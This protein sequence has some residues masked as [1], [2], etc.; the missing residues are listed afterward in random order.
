VIITGIERRRRWSATEKLRIV[1]ETPGP[2]AMTKAVAERHGFST[3]LLFTWPKQMLTTAMTG[4]APV[5]ASPE[6][7]SPMLAGAAGPSVEAT[8]GPDGLL[9]VCGEFCKSV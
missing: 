1:C 4:F 6:V 3:G 5:H 7:P 9:V 8:P 2:E